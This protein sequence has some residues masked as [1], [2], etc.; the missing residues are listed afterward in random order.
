MDILVSI[1][2]ITAIVLISVFLLGF[3]VF[4]TKKGEFPNIHIGGNKGL[5]DQ[6]VGC[7]TSQDAEA[8]ADKSRRIDISKIMNDIEVK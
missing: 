4:F 3:R 7:A 2:I 5:R 6:G 1:L 8:Q